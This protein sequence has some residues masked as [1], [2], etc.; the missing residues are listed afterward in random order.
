[1]TGVDGYTHVPRIA[2]AGLF[3]RLARDC[4]DGKRDFRLDLLPDLLRTYLE[5]LEK[6]RAIESEG[7]LAQTTTDTVNVL[8]ATRYATEAL[9]G[10]VS[11]KRIREIVTQAR[12]DVADA[13][14]RRMKPFGASTTPAVASRRLRSHASER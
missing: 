10:P 13:S 14:V 4:L 7:S 5:V 3:E 11:E 9:E 6:L 2:S 1:M 12:H 8:I